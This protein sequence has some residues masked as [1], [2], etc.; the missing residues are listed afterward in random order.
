M[1]TGMQAGYA[2]V[3]KMCVCVGGVQCLNM[4]DGST[5]MEYVCRGDRTVKQV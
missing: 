1:H 4:G 3:K 5:V 2:A